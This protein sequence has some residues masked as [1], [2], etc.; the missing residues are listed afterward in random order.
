MEI[1]ITRAGPNVDVIVEWVPFLLRESTP[2]DGFPKKGVIGKVSSSLLEM[3]RAIWIEFTGLCPRIPNTLK[4][5]ALMAFAREVGGPVEQNQLQEVIF[6]QY[7]TDGIFLDVPALVAAAR[8]AGLPEEEAR[9][10]LEDGRF[11]EK[12]RDEVAEVVSL[13][14]SSPGPQS[15]E[16]FQDAFR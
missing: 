14:Q 7:F 3:G 5:H 11:E 15:P 9:V 16:V 8:E 4:A 1:G 13:G 12:V 2:E 10:A 6:R